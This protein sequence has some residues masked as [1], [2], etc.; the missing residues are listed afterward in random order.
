M[1]GYVGGR[2]VIGKIQGEREG[3]EEEAG[4]KEWFVDKDDD[5]DEVL[6]V[7]GE[8]NMLGW[9]W[10]GFRDNRVHDVK[11]INSLYVNRAEAFV[12]KVFIF[13]WV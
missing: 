6:M 10:V 7:D 12:L 3:W 1:G 11:K 8:G 5:G 13:V 4:R 2:A 9:R